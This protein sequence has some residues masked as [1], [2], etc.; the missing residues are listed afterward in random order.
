MAYFYDVSTGS[1]HDIFPFHAEWLSK[2][3]ALERF[4]NT[5]KTDF[6]C[7]LF[8][9]KKTLNYFG[10]TGHSGGALS[11]SEIILDIQMGKFICLYLSADQVAYRPTSMLALPYS[12]LTGALQTKDN[13]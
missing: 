8:E 10:S 2:G 9:V 4:L 1:E 6:V 12:T 3:I 13:D 5:Y 7:L 11:Q